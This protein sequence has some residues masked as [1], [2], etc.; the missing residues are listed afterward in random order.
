MMA[1]PRITA[2]APPL[3]Y[4]PRYSC[5]WPRTHRFPMWKFKDLY[6]V[7]QRQRWFEPALVHRP[8]PLA[9]SAFTAVHD[10]DYYRA[11]VDGGLDD[12]AARRIAGH[13]N[14]CRGEHALWLFGVDEKKRSVPGV[15]PNEYTE[16]WGKVEKCFQSL[17]DTWTL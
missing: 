2:H 5:P 14:A 8:P 13:A 15:G 1:P 7:V 17:V 16:W 4:H 12:D 10:E 11:F 9:A 3:V 6:S